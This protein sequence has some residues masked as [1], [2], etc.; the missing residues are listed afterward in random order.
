[1]YCP[2]PGPPL[3]PVYEFA[4]RCADSKAALQETEPIC[5]YLVPNLLQV[6]SRLLGKPEAQKLDSRKYKHARVWLRLNDGKHS[7]H[8]SGG[9]QCSAAFLSHWPLV[10]DLMRNYTETYAALLSD[11]AAASALRLPTTI[12]TEKLHANG[13]TQIFPR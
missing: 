4:F 8:R 1:V 13:Y 2:P 7:L 10:C 12:L 11:E 3:P 9:M 5:G 6:N